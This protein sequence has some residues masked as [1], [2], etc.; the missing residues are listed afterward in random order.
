MGIQILIQVTSWFKLMEVLLP[1]P[2]RWMAHWELFCYKEKQT[3]AIELILY[4]TTG[5]CILNYASLL[6]V[7]YGNHRPWC[8][9]G[10]D[11]APELHIISINCSL[12]VVGNSATPMCTASAMG[13]YSS[14]GHAWHSPI[15]VLVW[16]LN[17]PAASWVAS[18]LTEV[19]ICYFP[20]AYLSPSMKQGQQL[21]LTCVRDTK[22]GA[23]DLVIHWFCYAWVIRATVTH[24]SPD[25]LLIL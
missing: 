3:R 17:Y 6:G 12:W 20:L 10:Y 5:K 7:R 8:L 9:T 4:V 18:T 11:W 22:S 16:L 15:L 13:A 24:H 2:L 25:G 1:A 14:S 19:S 21:G 23:L